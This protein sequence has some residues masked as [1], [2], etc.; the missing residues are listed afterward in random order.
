MLSAAHVLAMDAKNLLDVVDSVRIRYPE[1]DEIFK[2]DKVNE[3]CGVNA[4]GNDATPGPS[5]SSETVSSYGLS[6]VT[7][8]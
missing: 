6:K 7:A 5:S 3:I 2:S 1:V 8:T 4:R